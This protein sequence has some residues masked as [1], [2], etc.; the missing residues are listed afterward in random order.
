M[1]AKTLNM[2]VTLNQKYMIRFLV[3]ETNIFE[4]DWI[5]FIDL[6]NTRAKFNHTAAPDALS[7]F[8]ALVDY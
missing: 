1:Y 4:K 2:I 8:S 3:R 5:E 7:Y 6:Y